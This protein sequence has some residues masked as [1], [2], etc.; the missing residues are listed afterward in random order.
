MS[1][2]PVIINKLCNCKSNRFQPRC[3]V[4]STFKNCIIKV[5]MFYFNR[6]INVHTVGGQHYIFSIKSHPEVLKSYIGFSVPQ[7][8][9]A[10]LS[11]GQDIEVRTTSL[12]ECLATIVLEVD[13]MQKKVWVFFQYQCIPNICLFTYF[14]LVYI[15]NSFDL[16]RITQDPYDSEEMAR[17][18]QYQFTGQAFTVNQ[19]LAF[20][21]GNKKVLSILVKDLEG[22]CLKL[23][24]FS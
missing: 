13:F 4:I 23:Y 7:R 22:N 6:Y 15:G 11:L 5:V 14:I 8:R 20:T 2:W 21:Y 12:T 17:E 9:W 1:Y 10:V 18:F 19:Q 16:S 3:Q 24:L